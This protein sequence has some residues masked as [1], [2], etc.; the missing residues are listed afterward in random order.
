MRPKTLFG[1][2]LP[3]LRWAG[4]DSSFLVALAAPRTPPRCLSVHGFKRVQSRLRFHFIRASLSGT[5]AALHAAACR[6]TIPAMPDARSKAF[7][8]TNCIYNA[9]TEELLVEFTVYRK[10]LDPV[11]PS[12]RPYVYIYDDVPEAIADEFLDDKENGEFYNESIR[13]IYDYTRIE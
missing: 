13:G 11:T 6:A 3:H 5:H 2:Q 12:G 9:A 1:E 4:R 7:F 10:K 8:G